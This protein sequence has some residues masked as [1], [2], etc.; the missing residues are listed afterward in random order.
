[1]VEEQYQYRI[2]LENRTLGQRRVEEV[3]SNNLYSAIIKVI[4]EDLKVLKLGHEL[5]FEDVYELCGELPV[6]EAMIDKISRDI[7]VRQGSRLGGSFGD[8]IASAWA[9]ADKRN[10]RILAP[11]IQALLR[12]AYEF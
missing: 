7:E 11:S 1:M 4:R 12:S 5:V 6:N 8:A 3:T 2:T 10:K 9:K